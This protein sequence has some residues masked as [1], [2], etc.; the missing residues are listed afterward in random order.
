MSVREA[1][2][3][4]PLHCGINGPS[5]PVAEDEPKLNVNNI[6]GNVLAGFNKDF[7]TLV[8]LRIDNVANFKPWLQNF[9]PRIATL[10]EVIPFNR[11]FKSMRRRLKADPLLK[12]TW[13]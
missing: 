2:A 10:G 12:V 7:Q 1:P 11:L 5:H 8:F 13:I 9:T 4:D 3:P 6:Q